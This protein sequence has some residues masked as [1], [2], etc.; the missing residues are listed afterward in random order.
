MNI[1]ANKL[2]DLMKEKPASSI[3]LDI[4][5]PPKPI[6]VNIQQWSRVFW[7]QKSNE[8]LSNYDFGV[9]LGKFGDNK[10]D[11]E[12]ICLRFAKAIEEAVKHSLNSEDK[13]SEKLSLHFSVLNSIMCIIGKELK[14]MKLENDTELELI[15]RLHGFIDQYVTILRDM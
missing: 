5:E 12:Q 13:S 11:V 6:E 7:G 10:K 4:P 3:P 14:A 2:D 15:S 1:N 9:S 8:M